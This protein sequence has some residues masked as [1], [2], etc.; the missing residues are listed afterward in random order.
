MR[1]NV[2]DATKANIR[3]ERSWLYSLIVD[4]ISIL[5]SPSVKS[6]RILIC[7]GC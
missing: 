1:S 3:F 2:D 5:N 6:E 7:F 4:F